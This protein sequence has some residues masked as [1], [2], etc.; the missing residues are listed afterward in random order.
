M[1]ERERR[2]DARVLQ[3][4][5]VRPDLVGQQH[6]LVDDR[7]RRH[8]RHVE[9]LAVGELERLD[10]VA[11]RLADDVE[12]ALERVGDRDLGPA[13]DEHLPDDRLELPRRLG[14][15][16]A[17]DRYVAPAEQ[18]LA[19]VLDRALD[20]VLAGEARG[21]FPREEHHA[22]AVLAEGR[23]RD[24]LP[25]ELLAEELVRDL[26]Q[27]PRAVRELWVVADRAPVGQVLEDQQALLDD[28]VALL[29]L[30]VRDE[31][32][33]AG[34]VLVG[35][36][37]E[38]LGGGQA[39]MAHLAPRLARHRSKPALFH[40]EPWNIPAIPRC[41]KRLPQC[42]KTAPKPSA[43]REIRRLRRRRASRAA[44]RARRRR[45]SRPTRAAR[46]G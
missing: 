4:L 46:A 18:H 9:L 27:Q 39:R 29:A 41:F 40:G 45:E 36:V 20:L 17:V 26:D 43:A 2:H 28:L 15:V 24:A 35:R 34:V 32:D 11:G 19:L 13:P 8:R 16:G 30:D 3:V 14:E 5:V 38:A 25:R 31:A 33:A 1:D 22:D 21:R 6:A 10:G 42:G 44:R 12:L 37:I 7:A 23:Q